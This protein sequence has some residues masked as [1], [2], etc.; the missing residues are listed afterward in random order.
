MSASLLAHVLSASAADPAQT[1]QASEN[2][3]A[4]K[5]STDQ[6]V[7]DLR[8]LLE[9]ASKEGW[10]E[11]KTR[12]KIAETSIQ[13]PEITAGRS[14]KS[15]TDCAEFVSLLII[16]ETEK[17]Y[18]R[19]GLLAEAVVTDEISEA[20]GQTLST[21][22]GEKWHNDAHTLHLPEPQLD[23]SSA[24]SCDPSLM[25][26]QV[27]AQ[28]P[29]FLP[30][31]SEGPLLKSLGNMPRTLRERVG[32]AIA[33]NA[34][35]QGDYRGAQRIADSLNDSDLYMTPYWQTDRRQILLQA[36]LIETSNPSRAIKQLRWIADRDGAEQLAAVDAL[37]A[38]ERPAKL[39]PVLN[40]MREGS[41][42][43]ARQVALERQAL[44]AVR[45][46]TL[47]VA[48]EIISELAANGV[49]LPDGLISGLGDQLG[50]AMASDN[51]E[52]RI[53][54]LDAF[55]RIEAIIGRDYPQAQPRLSALAKDATARLHETSPQLD[56]AI[57]QQ[58]YDTPARIVKA[59]YSASASRSTSGA[60]VKGRIGHY[61][62]DLIEMREVLSGE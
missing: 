3:Q 34:V 45:N 44:D 59:G 31:H 11:L 18:L 46:N 32:V 8:K 17:S 52:R 12:P 15:A 54:A 2:S 23:L 1:P 58:S 27:L 24:A 50:L 62:S 16:A 38:I 47:G 42:V 5:T 37:W 28:K 21:L 35:E 55:M 56:A 33:L 60:S 10:V 7:T 9:M 61:Q 20:L 6:K 51:T 22:L 53:E 49:D 25:P 48:A 4:Q 57:A 43:P 29:E 14:V 19:N 39:N 41:S 30:A 13:D 26:W 40:R 36:R